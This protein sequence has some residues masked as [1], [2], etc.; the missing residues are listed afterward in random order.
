LLLPRRPIDAAKD[1]LLKQVAASAHRLNR[2]RP[3]EATTRAY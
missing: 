3:I 2:L 1:L